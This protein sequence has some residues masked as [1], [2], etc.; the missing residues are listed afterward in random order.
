[1]AG[2]AFLNREA[3]PVKVF[4]SLHRMWY[5]PVVHGFRLPPAVARSSCFIGFFEGLGFLGESPSLSAIS[6]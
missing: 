6:Y 2:A 3:F 1:M 5:I 4:A